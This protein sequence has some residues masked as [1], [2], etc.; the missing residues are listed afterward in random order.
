M[1]HE[2]GINIDREWAAVSAAPTL[3]LGALIVAGGL[4]WVALHFLY[5]HRIDG[6]KED[7]ARLC[8][9]LEESEKEL[10]SRLVSLELSPSERQD[11]P[12][13][14]PP[15]ATAAP[16]AEQPR[17]T[18][19][20]DWE[21]VVDLT[22]GQVEELMRG[23]STRT[24]A[25]LRVI[26]EHGPIIH[27]TL[28][29]RAGIENYGHFQGRVTLRTRTVTGNREAYLLTWD[30]WQSKANGGVGHYAVTAKTHRSLRIYFHLD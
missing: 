8:R 26:A 18:D 13:V 29:D 24:R 20:Y 9:R 16:A 1:S 3:F 2:M 7:I 5:R 15:A 11:A 14:L 25:G 4:I 17:N 19:G 28:L 10:A 22:P 12:P 30:D 27:A 21:N 23:C 6:F